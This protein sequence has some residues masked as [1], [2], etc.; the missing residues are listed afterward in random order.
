MEPIIKHIFD[1]DLYK[2]TMLA[3]AVKQ[4]PEGMVHYEFKD[5]NNTCYPKGFAELLNEQINY[6]G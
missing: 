5:R 2:L 3:F 4:Y 6:L 1:T